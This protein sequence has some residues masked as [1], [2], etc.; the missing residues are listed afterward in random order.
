[1]VFCSVKK[2]IFGVFVLSLILSSVSVF[3]AESL[4]ATGSSGRTQVYFHVIEATMINYD[5]DPAEAGR[6][7]TVRFKIENSGAENAKD[8][9]VELLPKYPFSLVGFFLVGTT[10]LYIFMCSLLLLSNF[11]R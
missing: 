4:L 2:I 11:S 5:P 1:M 10:F 6:Y 3:G 8:M 7:V 9:V